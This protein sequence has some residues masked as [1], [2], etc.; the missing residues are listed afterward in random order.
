MAHVPIVQSN[1]EGTVDVNSCAIFLSPFHCGE[2]SW[3]C[4]CAGYIDNFVVFHAV[5]MFP[6]WQKHGFSTWESLCLLTN[7]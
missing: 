7:I 2:L 5:T 1:A 6:H 4:Q 3:T